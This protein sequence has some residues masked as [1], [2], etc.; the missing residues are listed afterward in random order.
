MPEYIVISNRIVQKDIAR[1]Y[2]NAH[3]DYLTKLKN[4]GKLMMA[5]KFSDGSG[6]LYVLVADTLN[7][8]LYLA[9][10]DPYH[11]NKFRNYTLKEWEKSYNIKYFFYSVSFFFN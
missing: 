11:S 5:G 3:V 6:G 4:S 2:R 1:S 9:N 7:E 8:A 10:A